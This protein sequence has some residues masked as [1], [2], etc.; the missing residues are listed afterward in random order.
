MKSTRMQTHRPL[1]IIIFALILSVVSNRARPCKIII[2]PAVEKG[3]KKTQNVSNK[4]ARLI[5]R[6][7]LHLQN[8]PT[9]SQPRHTV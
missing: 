4:Q 6:L 9:L 2:I 5:E 8:R 3:G 1:F 7:N